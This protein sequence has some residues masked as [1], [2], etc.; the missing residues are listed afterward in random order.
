[1]A[2]I[3]VIIFSMNRAM[4]LDALI[5]SLF[6]HC[7]DA[8]SMEIYVLYRT[9]DEIHTRQYQ[10]L[11]ERYPDIHFVFEKDFRRDLLS[12]V[13]PYLSGSRANKLYWSISKF[14]EFYFSPGT[15][16]FRLWRGLV[17]NTILFFARI[18]LTALEEDQFCFFLVDDNIFTNK[19]TLQSV[20]NT[21]QQRRDLLGFS[22]RL[23]ENTNYCYMSGQ[24]QELPA[25]KNIG[26][27]IL[28]F[29]WISADQD[30]GYPFEISS[31]IYP[32]K[33]VLPLLASISFQAPN[34]LEEKMAYHARN[35]R[36]SH[37]YLGCY[38]CSTAFCNPVNIVQE[39]IANR[40]GETYYYQT[41]EL[42]D[43]F[44]Q[45]ERINVDI[46]KGFVSHSCHQEVEL[47]FEDR[48]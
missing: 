14:G 25:F 20:K 21:L 24:S 45:G 9:T 31:S 30:F 7:N 23:G 36:T 26:E 13:N 33:I 12:I 38:R 3:R 39:E 15:F 10:K 43:R 37:P 48:G 44:E 16:L 40:V 6:Y 46:F 5:R 32:M 27:N 4:Q 18:L 41:D 47:I 17:E 35:F 11:T 2:D 28:I 29:R 1:M 8:G 19:F 22:F 34:T 42:R